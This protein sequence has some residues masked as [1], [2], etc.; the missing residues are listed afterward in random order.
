MKLEN[1]ELKSKLI[2]R[3]KRVEGQVRGV[4]AMLESGRDC[5]EIIQQ[6]SAVQSAV[7]STS[8]I[9]LEESALE[10]LL[11][12]SSQPLDRKTQEQSLRELIALLDKTV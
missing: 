10:C 8:R 6:L 2:Q 12:E 9:L 4:Q 5:R 1:S 3:L 11:P 7:H